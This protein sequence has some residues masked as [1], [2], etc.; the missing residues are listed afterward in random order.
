MV[1][2]GCGAFDGFAHFQIC[3]VL[4]DGLLGRVWR[5]F[6]LWVGGVGGLG[7][8]LGSWVFTV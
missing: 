5:M 3:G 4:D 2:V 6:R 8:F 7:V 1:W